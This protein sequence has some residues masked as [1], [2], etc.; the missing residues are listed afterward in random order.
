MEP[1]LAA[2]ARSQ[3]ALFT[4]DQALTAGYSLRQAQRRRE[5][6]AWE[7]MQAGVYRVAGAPA[8]W[9]QRL[10]AACLAAGTGAVASHRSAARLW[11]I[12]ESR[13]PLVEISVPPGRQPRLNGVLVHRSRDLRPVVCTIREGIPVT[14]PVRTILDLGAVQRPQAVEHS[15]EVALGRQHVTLQ[16]LRKILDSDARRGRQGAGVLRILLD[17]RSEGEELTQSV[18]E[19]RMLRLCRTAG[20]PEPVCQHEVRNGH[21]LVGRIDFAYSADR[22]AIEVDGYE[23][24]ASLD[25]FRHDRVRQNELV[26]LG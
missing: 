21:R 17:K 2:V 10:L 19:A 11:G 3:M 20:L 6:G 9:E 8:S 24:H 5:T 1:A 4:H 14:T 12:D 18:L 15:L 23:S 13:R 22:V 25:A 16:G 26:A 7:Q